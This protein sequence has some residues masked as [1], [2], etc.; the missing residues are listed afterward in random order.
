MAGLLSPHGTVRWRGREG[1]WDDVVGLGFCVVLRDADPK[2]VLCPDQLRALAGIGA[3]VVGIADAPLGDLV[4]DAEGKYGAFL[5]THGA[6]A[7]ITRPDFYVFGGA[8]TDK[9][10]VGLV[11]QLLAVLAEN[12]VHVSAEADVAA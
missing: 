4:V 9:D 10:L 12:G 6:A 11:D 7:M 5:D 3:H 2:D 8:S 1:R